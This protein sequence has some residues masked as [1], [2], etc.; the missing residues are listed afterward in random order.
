MQVHIFDI[1]VKRLSL[2]HIYFDVLV[3]SDN[4]DRV[5]EFAE[6]YLS[7][8]GI[9][10]D[11]ITQLECDFCHSEIANPEVITVIEQHGYCIIPLR[12]S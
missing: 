1:V 5:K 2:Q 7:S 11:S 8:L 6:I 9:N 3:D 4:K 10:S 12:K